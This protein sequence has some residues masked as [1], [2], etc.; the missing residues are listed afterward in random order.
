[1]LV[2][3]FFG[4]RKWVGRQSFCDEQKGTELTAGMRGCKIGGGQGHLVMSTE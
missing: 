1:M 4:L 3:F 2:K